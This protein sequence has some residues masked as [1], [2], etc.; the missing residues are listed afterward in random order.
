MKTLLTLAASY[1]LFFSAP[2]QTTTGLS[3]DSCYA[4]ALRHYPLLRQQTLIAQGQDYAL[5]NL[6][7][8]LWP[9][10]TLSGQA[11]YQSDVTS[12]PIHFPGIDIKTPPKD[13]Y[14]VYAEL[15]QSLTDW[16]SHPD[17]K[18]LQIANTNLQEANLDAELYKLRDRVNQLYFNI[19]L[20]D[21]RILQNDI[22][23]KDIDAG[24]ARV[25]S[26]VQNGTDYQGS[27][28]KLQ[29]ELLKNRQRDIELK[30]QRQTYCNMLC[31][32]TGREPGEKLRLEIP[33]APLPSS[34][35]NRP[36]IRAFNLKDNT[37]LLQSRLLDRAVELTRPGG[38]LV[39]CTCSL[40]PEEGEAQIEALL[41]RDSRLARK[42][43][44][45]AEVFGHAEFVTAAGDLR[46]LPH[47]LPNEDPRWAGLDG[48]F[49]ARLVRTAG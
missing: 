11:A 1:L 39:Y 23:Q 32:L 30:A 46:T 36:E 7:K 5:D 18:A 9:Q 15:S 31:L 44:T 21:E 48:F 8:N 49:A 12:I 29:A 10:L 14:K 20:S 16:I 26:A 45:A 4:Q 37:L 28:D 41:A 35:I 6:S 43:I 2:A 3:L 42:P 25:R 24:I 13:Q 27:L 17:Q 33:P 40:E 47:Y 19:L 34:A 22:S 38:T